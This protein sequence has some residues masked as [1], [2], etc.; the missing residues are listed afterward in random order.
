LGFLGGLTGPTSDLGIAGRDSTLLAVEQF[1]QRGG[2][3]G[4]P[5]EL[6]EF[7]D[8]QQPAVLHELADRIRLASVAGVV[9][10]MTSSVAEAWIPVANRLELTTV[11]PTVTSSD[12][13]GQDDQFFRVCSTTREYAYVSA[14]HHMRASSS[15]RFALIRDDS[16]AAYTRSWAQHFADRVAALGGQVVQQAVFSSGKQAVSIS[17]ALAQALAYQPDAMVV[18]A[19]ARDTALLA[20]LLRKQGSTIPLSA[21][22]WAATDQLLSMGGR[23]VDQLLVAQYFDPNSQHDTYRGFVQAFI[24]RF[25]RQPGFAEVAGFDAATVLLR[26]LTE[27][28]SGETLKQALL[29]IRQFDGLQQPVVF[30]GSGDATR[31]LFVTQIL[32]SR[33]KVVVP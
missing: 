31:P 15:K 13:T 24:G 25:G 3:Q 32:D 18:V 2:F 16:N 7:D 19:N 27:K 10:P 11:S 20:Q 5:V 14:E 33:F 1:N 4:Q 30:D 17:E 29:R 23:A 22:E 8:K 28:T 26:G 6:V 12:F 21:A 9:G